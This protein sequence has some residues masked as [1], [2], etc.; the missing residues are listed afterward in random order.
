MF[1]V[2]PRLNTAG[3]QTCSQKWNTLGAIDL[4]DWIQQ[5]LVN[6]DPS[7]AIKIS[8]NDYGLDKYYGQ[9]NEQGQM[10]G[11]GRLCRVT[12]Q[13]Y[14]GNFYEGNQHKFGREIDYHTNYTG[15][16]NMGKKLDDTAIE[17][18]SG[19]NDS[20]FDQSRLAAKK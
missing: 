15:K 11:I 4:N 7:L 14:E 8:T 13:V 2:A 19:T 20:W 6:F 3:Y 12:G 17:W 9:I 10:H 16:W 5:G 1:T 18:S